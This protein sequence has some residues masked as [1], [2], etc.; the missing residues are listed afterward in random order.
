MFVVCLLNAVYVAASTTLFFIRLEEAYR[1][2]VCLIVCD[3]ENLVNEV[4][5]HW[6]AVAPKTNKRTNI[7]G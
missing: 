3:I 5:A 6:R 4:I 7:A 1:M 2:C